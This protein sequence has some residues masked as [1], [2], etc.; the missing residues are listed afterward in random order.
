M[1]TKTQ[2]NFIYGNTNVKTHEVRKIPFYTFVSDKTGSWET[3][4][5]TFFKTK[6]GQEVSLCVRFR[7]SQTI[8]CCPAHVRNRI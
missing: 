2:N 4:K 6:I 5:R 1:L 3:A 8:L 7:M